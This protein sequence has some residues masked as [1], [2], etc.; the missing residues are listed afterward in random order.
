MAFSINKIG[1]GHHP[2]ADTHTHTIQKQYHEFVLFQINAKFNIPKTSNN[3]LI[4]EVKLLV[5]LI[6]YTTSGV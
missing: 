6:I 1:F 2:H 4:Y 3:N 5:V